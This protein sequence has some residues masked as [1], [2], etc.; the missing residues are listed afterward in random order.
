MS[1]IRHQQQGVHKEVQFLEFFDVLVEEAFLEADFLVV[2][3]FLAALW[4]LATFDAVVTFMFVFVDFAG[5]LFL[6]ED[7]GLAEALA[8][9]DSVE[10]AFLD[11]FGVLTLLA[12]FDD[13]LA[14]E[15]ALAEDPA[16]FS[17][18]DFFPAV[19]FGET[20][21]GAA[22]LMDVLV[23]G[24]VTLVTAFV[25]DLEDVL[26]ACFLSAAFVTSFLAATLISL[27]GPA[28]PFGCLK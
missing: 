9:P 10:L 16:V 14:F 27:I 7:L 2:V 24:F 26:V 5:R 1:S 12:N 3:P 19:F 18:T 13:L 22:F 20:L 28:G 11:A 6:A 21:L 4:G 15:V 23:A 25:V 8:L 17:G